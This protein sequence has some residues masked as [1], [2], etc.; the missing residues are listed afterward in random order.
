MPNFF[1][2]VKEKGS[3]KAE[4][5]ILGLN[6]ALGGLASK[7]ALAAGGFFGASML[8]SGMKQAINLA[9][10]QELQERKLEKALGGHTGALLAQ[11]SALQQASVFGDEAIIQQQAYLASIGLSEQQIKEMIPVTL[12]LAAAT[13]MSLESAV[14]NTAKTL[15]GMTGELGESVGALKDLTAEQLKAGEGIDVM[16]EM[17]K[18]MAE[19]ETKTMSGA[20]SQLSNNI[21][22]MAEEFGE[23]LAP[24]VLKVASALSAFVEGTTAFLEWA[25]GINSAREAQ[26]QFD[27]EMKE[28]QELIDNV[29]TEFNLTTD[30]SKDLT[31]QMI[32]LR[33]QLKEQSKDD[34]FRAGFFNPA[35]AA[36]KE[37]GEQIEDMNF[38][39]KDQIE[40]S[41]MQTNDA[42]N[43][44]ITQRELR[45]ETTDYIGNLKRVETQTMAQISLTE[46]WAFK[47]KEYIKARSVQTRED[48]KGYAMTK[49]SAR[50]AMISVVQ[51]E[52]MEAIAG[53]IASIFKNVAFPLNA[54]LAAGAGATVSSAI[55]RNLQAHVPQFAE[56]GDFVT[57]GRQLIM[58]GDNPSGQERVQITPLGGDPAPNAPSGS[59]LQ[60]NISGNVLS[61]DFVEGELAES[62]KEAVRRGTDFGLS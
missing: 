42:N 8:L 33:K 57:N 2:N 52:T 3:K 51:A 50:D 1:I 11:A 36:Q 39:L 59:T 30:S 10:E 45:K 60:F 25:N 7:A 18:G 43:Q 6:N 24:A 49:G 9:G 62:I 40:L 16:R 61:Q 44:L 37:L 22:D 14:K 54:I 31:A 32:D 41:G 26:E 48:L 38:A 47:G 58:V 17:F 34:F 5:N 35:I 15:S 28:S 12:D 53:L 27:K 4:K 13:G 21:G 56:G 20:L 55:S 29:K 19:T 46:S 23:L